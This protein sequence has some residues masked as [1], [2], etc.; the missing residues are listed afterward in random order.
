MSGKCTFFHGLYHVAGRIFQEQMCAFNAAAVR[1][2]CVDIWEPFRQTIEEW[3][4]QCR[5]VYDKFYIMKP[6]ERRLT[7]SVVRSFSEGVV[8]RENS[9]KASGGYCCR[10]GYI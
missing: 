1:T 3:L 10:V 8:R 7:S 5:I 6:P 2:A 9:S 4:P